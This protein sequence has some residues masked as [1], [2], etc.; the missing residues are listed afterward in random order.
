MTGAP[1]LRYR[2]LTTPTGTFTIR[3]HRDGAISTTWGWADCEDTLG[4][5]LDGADR[6]DALAPDLA[7]RLEA[8]FNGRG[9]DFSDIPTPDGPPFFMRCWTACRRIPR[10]QTRTYGQ[11]AAAAGSGPGAARAAG[12]AMRSN[13]LPVVVPCH[14]V[15]AAGGRLGGFAGADDPS[16][17]PLEVKR[18]LLRMER[19]VRADDIPV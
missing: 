9:V 13:P 8:Y 10:G 15:L 19:A 4:H 16:S 18:W 1:I 5:T 14:R 2:S 3:L 7:Q 12:Q 6:D 11:L 17:R